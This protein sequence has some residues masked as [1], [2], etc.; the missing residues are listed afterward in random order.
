MNSWFA[1]YCRR[2]PN[3]AD[4]ARGYWTCR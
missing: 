2:P 3:R 4:L 1:I